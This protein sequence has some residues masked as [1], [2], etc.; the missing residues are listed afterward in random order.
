[1]SNAPAHQP[2]GI[3]VGGQFMATHHSDDVPSLGAPI[4][5]PTNPALH[6]AIYEDQPSNAERRDYGRSAVDQVL[7]GD[8]FSVVFTDEDKAGIREEADRDDSMD[9]A[10]TRAA[11]AAPHQLGDALAR[12]L[13]T[14]RVRRLAIESH[15]VTD[16][17]DLY[18][19]AVAH[20]EDSPSAYEAA[21][22]RAFPHAGPI[23]YAKALA[24]QKTLPVEAQKRDLANMAIVA[25]RDLVL[26]AEH[27]EVPVEENP[28]FTSHP[29]SP[30]ERAIDNL[31]AVRGDPTWDEN[32]RY[33]AH[34]GGG[35]GYGNV[36]I[37][38]IAE[39]R[40]AAWRHTPIDRNK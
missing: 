10:L 39:K 2:A 34:H 14:I 26:R 12:D 32:V 8:D 20:L 16:R 15:Y 17:Q 7:Y 35:A 5:I 1:M 6:R 38:Q 19:Q 22:K 31:I 33:L 25:E 23:W 4:R 11:T 27:P 36:F 9:L 37:R 40:L 24:N 21:L 13:A 3:P 18:E 30:L 29:V 28:D